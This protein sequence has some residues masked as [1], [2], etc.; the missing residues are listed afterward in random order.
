MTDPRITQIIIAGQQLSN[1]AF[2]WAQSEGRVLTAADCAMLKKLHQQWDEA[3][4]AARSLAQP[5][6]QEGQAT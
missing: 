4:T 6:A 1:V 2:N 5:A 3:V